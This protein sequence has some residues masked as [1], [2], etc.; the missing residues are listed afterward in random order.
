MKKYISNFLIR[1][2][3]LAILFFLLDLAFKITI[4]PFPLFLTPEFLGT[5][6]LYLMVGYVIAGIPFLIKLWKKTNIWQNFAKKWKLDEKL[7][8]I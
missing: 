4:R 7:E 2:L 8:D 1:G 5:I 3:E 6:I